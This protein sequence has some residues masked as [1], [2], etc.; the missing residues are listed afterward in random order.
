[1]NPR[2]L[3]AIGSHLK[4]FVI[5]ARLRSGLRPALRLGHT[6]SYL[7]FLPVVF[8]MSASVMADD[9][10]AFNT[11]PDISWERV[12]PLKEVGQNLANFDFSGQVC[13]ITC[14][15]P[16]PTAVAYIMSLGFPEAA[17]APRAN[18]L[19]PTTWLDSVV[20]VDVVSWQTPL[21]GLVDGSLPGV[22]TRIQPNPGFSRTRGFSLALQPLQGGL[23]RI[24]IFLANQEVLTSLA[25]SPTFTL[26]PTRRYRL[27][28]AS[29]G[30][31]HTGRIFDLTAPGSPVAE[32]SVTNS[33]L[34][35][36]PGRCGFGAAM[37]HP[38]PIDVTFDNFL[39]W[40]GSPPPLTIRQGS[41]PGTIELL[42]DTRRSMAS[43]LE[44]TTDL[45]NPAAWLPATPA[46]TGEAGPSLVRSFSSSAPRAFF[47]TKSL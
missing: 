23:G 16:S 12:E 11:V 19:A 29:R 17:A 45:T 46:V 38:L 31:R 20:S 8:L 18:L 14:G 15:V 22:F 30:D 27:V 37:P 7:R 1:M 21:P 26:D 32:I 35:T 6:M 25:Q 28:L 3:R 42:A 36:S 39:S 9:E 24:R 43:T 13:R 44:T 40:D 5:F 34:A 47:R 10:T 2:Q 4:D 41:A 33:N